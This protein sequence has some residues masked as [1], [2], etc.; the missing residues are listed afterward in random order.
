MKLKIIS[1][2]PLK[3]GR[4]FGKE[5]ITVL[6]VGQDT[7]PEQRQTTLKN[8]ALIS[9]KLTFSEELGRKASKKIRLWLQVPSI[10]G[11][12]GFCSPLKWDLFPLRDKCDSSRLG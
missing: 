3:N 9:K 6:S 12:K 10:N 1:F 5:P 4:G 8:N 2:F 7:E 11:G